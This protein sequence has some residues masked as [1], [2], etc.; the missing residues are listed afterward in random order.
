LISSNKLI[1]VC[2]LTSVHSSFDIRIFQKEAKSLV[3]AGY[4]VTLLSRHNKEETVKGIKILPLPNRKNRIERMTKTA[5]MVYRKAVKIDADIYHFHDPELIPIGLLLKHH[6][7]RVVYDVHE[8]VPRQI[9]SKDHIIGLFRKPVSAFIEVIEAFSAKRFD[10]VVTA[11]PFIGKRFSE[12][13]ANVVNVNNYPIASE[14]CPK[15]KTWVRKEKTVSYIGGISRIRGAFEM[16]EA[17]GKTPYKL[18]LAGNIESRIKARLVQLPGWRQVDALGFIDKEGVKAIATRSMAGLVVFHPEPNHI[19]AQPNKM[20]EYMSAGIPVIASSFPLWMKII[21]END[22]G[23][24]VDPLN[25]D[26]IADA[27]RWIVEHPL[28]A[29]LMGENGRRA[30]TDKYNWELEERKILKL[31]SLLT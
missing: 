31:Y 2:I 18:L 15:N 10:A 27:I 6:G 22:C 4:N 11:T 13:G 20:F 25:A 1:K 9:F 17:I 12:L 24:C 30:V 8:D 28:K 7:K 14:L 21:N 3:N 23:I 19:D 26:E 5:W 29:K 16:V